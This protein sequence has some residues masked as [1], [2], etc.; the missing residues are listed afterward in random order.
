[1]GDCPGCGSML[2]MEVSKIFCPAKIN[3]FLEVGSARPDGYHNIDSVMQAVDLCDLVTVGICGGAGK[4]SVICTN[5]ALSDEKTNIAAKAA[6][7]YLEAAGIDD[8]DVHIDIE[9][10]IPIA[11]GLAGGS[12]DAAGVLL[13]MEKMLKKLGDYEL[14][15]VGASV[16]A[17]VP[18]C[19]M[20]GAA[21]AEG[22]GDL[23]TPVRSLPHDLIIV[24]A[25]GGEGVSTAE[26]YSNVAQGIRSGAGM[27]SALSR[28]NITAICDNM[29]NAFEK[30]VSAV[31]PAVGTAKQIMYHCGAHA[32]MMSG[33]GPSVFGIFTDNDLADRACD[34]LHA[35][36]YESFV[37]F[38]MM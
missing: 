26:A 10:Q 2:Y 31:R 19:M 11:A 20:R 24:I 22:I 27:I 5:P 12:T 18:F 3:L 8:L 37:C 28:E 17:D 13:L 6:K 4:V 30:T 23:L 14:Y 7:K 21:R 9:K 29:Y 25:K 32:A 35:A 15:E 1:M 38:P 36:G 34:C 16:G 33:S